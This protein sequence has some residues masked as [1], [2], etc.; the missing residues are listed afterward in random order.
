VGIP[1]AE[2]ILEAHVII[3]RAERDSDRLIDYVDWCGIDAEA[4]RLVAAGDRFFTNILHSLRS[5]GVNT[6]DPIATFLAL[7]RLGAA[8]TEEVFGAG[9]RDLTFPHKTRPVAPTEMFTGSFCEAQMLFRAS[10]NMVQKACRPLPWWSIRRTSTSSASW[11][12]EMSCDGW[13]SE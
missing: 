2:E 10:R 4:D 7:L 11:S 1:P 3:R 5:V 12:S 9:P 6:E 13:G 8:K